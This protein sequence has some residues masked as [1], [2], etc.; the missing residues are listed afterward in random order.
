MP[1]SD[2]DI[3][4]IVRR[5]RVYMITLD[6]CHLVADHLTDI[7]ESDIKRQ[8][9]DTIFSI[10]ET[11]QKLSQTLKLIENSKSYREMAKK[12]NIGKQPVPIKEESDLW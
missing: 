1:I 12:F 7:E 5:L 11:N 3:L 4:D 2:A 6:N 8:L 9:M 10:S